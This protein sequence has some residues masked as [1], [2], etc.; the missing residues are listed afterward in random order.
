MKKFMCLCFVM[1]FL[2]NLVGCGDSVEESVRT[3]SIANVPTTITQTLPTKEPTAS[4]TAQTETTTSTTQPETTTQVHVKDKFE[5]IIEP[6]IEADDIQPFITDVDMSY[7][8]INKIIRSGKAGA[9][10]YQG[11][12]V[13]PCDKNIYMCWEGIVD[14]N[15]EY[16]YDEDGV[17]SDAWGHGG[18]DCDFFFDV[19]NEKTIAYG[20]GNGG[21][22]WYEWDAQAN[23]F[24]D[25]LFLE[26]VNP[27]NK[28]NEYDIT[29]KYVYVS[30][31]GELIRKTQFDEVTQF[32]E[33]F[34]A[35]K[36]D[37]KWGYIGVNGKTVIPFEYDY[38]YNFED[39]I[40]AVCKDGKW[41]Y[42]DKENN[43]VIDFEFEATRPHYKGKAWVKQ[44]G[45]WGVI[46]IQ[47]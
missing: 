18:G 43:T 21:L 11:K 20:M 23:H 4:V 15:H 7:E 40:A 39:G 13:I 19:K 10:N 24:L 44:N 9:V 14:E 26:T 25:N 5:W 27:N 31:K 29:G 30:F 3:T 33:N 35:V 41:G 16:M 46:S 1:L 37:G 17:Q 45:K 2:C 42:I 8:K 6:S 36:K 22:S 32:R 47:L 28:A 34:A 12:I 38:A